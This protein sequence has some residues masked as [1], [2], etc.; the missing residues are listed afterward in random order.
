MVLKWKWVK[1]YIQLN[2]RKRK[3]RDRKENVWKRE[4]FCSISVYICFVQAYF[5]SVPSMQKSFWCFE[6]AFN[7]P[8]TEEVELVIG[9]AELYDGKG[10]SKCYL[11]ILC[12]IA[13]FKLQ[14]LH[15]RCYQSRSNNINNS[16]HEGSNILGVIWKICREQ[17][18]INWINII[19]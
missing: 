4:V 19:P 12:A 7:N 8:T 17:I 14:M 6:W 13:D 11:D 1:V 10:S 2:A 15:G 5:R 16:V 9:M 3:R 18:N